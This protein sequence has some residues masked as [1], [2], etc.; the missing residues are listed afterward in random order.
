MSRHSVAVIVFSLSLILF[1]GA[2]GSPGDPD[3][4][5]LSPD[6]DDATGASFV[7]VDVDGDGLLEALIGAPAWDHD[8]GRVWVVPL[9]ELPEPGSYW[10]DEVAWRVLEGEAPGDRVGDRLRQ[11][12][13]LTEP[14][15]GGL[16]DLDLA[17]VQWFNAEPGEEPTDRLELDANEDGEVDALIEGSWGDGWI[18][19]IALSPFIFGHVDDEGSLGPPVGGDDDDAA[20]ADGEDGADPVEPGPGLDPTGGDG[21]DPATDPIPAG[22]PMTVTTL[23]GVTLD[24][25]PIDTLVDDAAGAEVVLDGVLD[26]T[27]ELDLPAGRGG[28]PP[29]VSIEFANGVESPELGRHW[30]LDATS[31]IVRRSETGGHPRGDATDVFWFE[32]Q[33]LV[34][35]GD[36][37]YRLA[38]RTPE[39]FQLVGD[40]WSVTADGYTD[41]YGT[42]TSPACGATEQAEAIENQVSV[43][44]TGGDAPTPYDS[45]GDAVTTRWWLARRRDPHGNTI[46]YRYH[47]PAGE[48]GDP[49]FVG[50]VLLDTISWSQGWY[51]AP[52]LSR[53]WDQFDYRL[54]FGYEPREHVPFV[55]QAGNPGWHGSRLSEIALVARPGGPQELTSW[56]FDY[57]LQAP[58]NHRL[59]RDV[60]VHGHAVDGVTPD[61][62]RLR[63]F[64]YSSAWTSTDPSDL[65][66]PDTTLSSTANG[67]PPATPEINHVAT[68]FFHANHDALPDVLR[69]YSDIRWIPEQRLAAGLKPLV[70][71]DNPAEQCP[72]DCSEA[73]APYECQGMTFA[74][75]DEALWVEVW[76]N[77][78][79][80]G[81]GVQFEESTD[82][83][84]I[85]TSFFQQQAPPSATYD[86]L[87]ARIAIADWNGDGM[88]DF[89][90]PVGSI[91]SPE[92]EGWIGALNEDD[93]LPMQA[94]GWGVDSQPVWFPADVDGD[95]R[96]ERVFPPMTATAPFSALDV[97]MLLPTLAAG[98]PGSAGGLCRIPPDRAGP[99][100]PAWMAS[101]TSDTGTF[102]GG[103][104]SLRLPFFGGPYSE[105]VASS[106][107]DDPV[108]GPTGLPGYC[109]IEG[110]TGTLIPAEAI[111]QLDTRVGNLWLA[112]SGW[113]YLAQHIQLQDVNADGCADATVA[114]E[115]RAD[116]LPIDFIEGV[117]GQPGEV[118]SEVFY[119]NC[120]GDFL[121]PAGPISDGARN[122]LGAPFNRI[123]ARASAPASCDELPFSGLELAVS[124]DDPFPALQPWAA[125]WCQS[126]TFGDLCCEECGSMFAACD[127]FDFGEC[128]PPPEGPEDPSDP[129]DQLLPLQMSATGDVGVPLVPDDPLAW[130][131]LLRHRYARDLGH[132]GF[133]W[134][135]SPTV[136]GQWVD[137]DGDGRLEWLQVCAAAGYQDPTTYPLPVS[138]E[139]P[140]GDAI[141]A[142]PLALHFPQDHDDFG[143]QPGL[144]CP[145]DPASGGR[146]TDLDFVGGFSS[147]STLPFQPLEAE[148]PLPRP[149]Q[150]GKDFVAMFV[151]LDGDG[152]ADHVRSEGDD[153]V[154]RF[155][156]RT[157]PEGTL[158]AITYPSGDVDSGPL[159][160]MTGTSYLG[161]RFEDPTTHPLRP[162]PELALAEVVDGTGHRVFQRFG[163]RIDEG[164]PAGCA[165]VVGQGP[166]GGLFKSLHL[167]EWPK[168]G[169]EWFEGRYT[170]DGQLV[171]ASFTLPRT[172]ASPQPDS[173]VT[174]AG[175]ECLAPIPDGPFDGSLI[176]YLEDCAGFSSTHPGSA[177]IDVAAFLEDALQVAHGQVVSPA[178][179]WPG[180]APLHLGELA[181]PTSPRISDVLVDGDRARTLAISD[182]AVA[183]N[184]DDDLLTSLTWGP[185]DADHGP[186]LE[187]KL[188]EGAGAHAETITDEEYG[189]VGWALVQ[190]E[191]F[192]GTLGVATSSVERD[193]FGEVELVT[194]A[195]GETSVISAR[196]WCG[197]ATAT[198][199]NTDLG[200]GVSN[201]SG[202]TYDAA[203]RTL[204]T[205]STTGASTETVRD[206]FG[207]ALRTVTEPRAD[208]P[209]MT[210]WS[211]ATHDP[212]TFGDPNTPQ[213]ASTDGETATFEYLDHRGQVVRTRICALRSLPGRRWS[214]SSRPTSPATP[215][216]R[217][218]RTPSTRATGC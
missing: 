144:T 44:W 27:L 112:P 175:R 39:V 47:L 58:L 180:G 136:G 75:C 78:G 68:R 42:L 51:P 102:G 49:G 122:A 57:L 6:P 59:L 146:V 52:Q 48:P 25:T 43:F 130:D 46:V 23:D 96:M 12:E 189:W 174:Y 111:S 157:L 92:T 179:Q 162:Y 3:F 10:L 7:V 137:S 210:T 211:F 192:G 138:P 199:E 1:R 26:H 17:D 115:L 5:L 109:E 72:T 107:L 77:R 187:A 24:G 11:P 81:S 168:G 154:V 121:D 32:G 151:D 125:P 139:P 16:M 9:F 38:Q 67:L 149:G 76:I 164:R 190:T 98:Q 55:A 201:Q 140:A 101:H 100:P 133:G 20:P 13:A 14:L 89:L 108:M 184:P 93:E 143:V 135:S 203:C 202:A 159:A 188:V 36:G 66:G 90:G 142:Y 173:V 110:E 54:E 200:A 182:H 131:P 87:L 8:R 196:H 82:D 28:F 216:P 178:I 31:A 186:K 99:L 103:S 158:I 70:C 145:S 120:R 217:S 94:G 198:L 83:S 170:V 117:G 18:T 181:A 15:V 85:L 41:E 71:V 171:D 30:R 213:R 22:P 34:P 124:C 37:R 214:A 218:T 153:I 53:E 95:G 134:T 177:P 204:T 176:E 150:F 129:A 155:N 172:A 194:D 195:D 127:N 169:F 69:I 45:I 64:H 91:A 141:G 21:F 147:Q 206:G 212:A 40:V 80:D 185:A 163:C 209:A 56:T 65:F 123:R 63:R 132:P 126:L 84:I 208:Q 19:G 128:A 191:R 29:V 4:V 118:F 73:A 207:A 119:G 61:P 166:R 197:G 114:L 152:F 86:D 74:S 167:T 148:R 35:V 105:L 106:E 165:V 205:A 193:A 183:G 60:T 215:A 104:F 2:S 161:W 113:E 97:S 88:D 50:S 33:E 116:T 156:Q 79:E 62:I 160:D